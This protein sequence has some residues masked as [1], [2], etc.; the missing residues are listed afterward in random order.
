MSPSR[1]FLIS[2][3]S[4]RG[5]RAKQLLSPRSQ[6]QMAARLWSESGVP[7]GEL[8][9][10]ISGLYFRGK[11]TYATRFAAAPAGTA[12]LHAAGVFII[13]PDDGLWTPDRP[14]TADLVRRFGKGDV[15][16]AHDDYR[17]PLERAARALAR[18]IGPRCEVVLLG[19]IAT[20][21]Y[22]DVLLGAFGER[23][24]FP[25]EFVGRGD[26]SRGGLLLR[27]AASGTEL[28]Y[29]AVAGAVRRGPRPPK[30]PPKRKAYLP[31]SSA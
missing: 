7:I 22:T 28:E 23:L 30:L 11:I 18:A 15:D 13:T 5:R 20:T 19:S 27:A 29:A 8:F 1:V 24:M 25:S 17:R 31:S 2:P 3:A 6:F 9:A 16:A 14:L 10:F 12:A 21:K 4:C 26:M